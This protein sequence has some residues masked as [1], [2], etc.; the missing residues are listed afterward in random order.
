MKLC[1]KMAKFFTNEI[2]CEKDESM[3]DNS[4]VNRLLESLIQ[5]SSTDESMKKIYVHFH[6]KIFQN[7]LVQ[8]SRHPNANYGVQKMLLFCPTKEMVS[9]ISSLNNLTSYKNGQ[10]SGKNRLC[11]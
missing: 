7:N 11:A 10:I 8:L 3:F 2:F 1:K 9:E 6:E 5:V 4:G